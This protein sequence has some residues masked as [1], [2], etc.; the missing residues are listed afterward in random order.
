MRRYCSRCLQTLG[1][2][3]PDRCPG[4]AC[5]TPR[6]HRGWPSFLAEGTTIEERFIVHEI[7]GAGGAGITY[8]CED[9]TDPAQNSALKVLH[10]DRRHGV[11]ANRL[12]IEGELL[13]LLVHRHIV[14][15]HA[16]RLVGDGPVYLATRYMPGGSLEGTLRRQGPMRAPRVVTVGRQLALALDFIHSQGIVHRDL[17]PGNV[18]IETTDDDPVVRLADFG[19]ARVFRDQR[20]LAGPVGL[21]R[22]GVFIGTPEYAAPEQ[23][24]GEKDVGPA[25]DAFALGALL[26]YAACGGA[27]LKR[28]EIADWTA[29]RQRRPDPADRPRLADVVPDDVAAGYEDE[30]ADLDAIIDALMHPD[31]DARVS[32]CDVA[33]ALGAAPSDL[34]PRD[35][36]PLAPRTLISA[37]DDG[38]F[39]DDGVDALVPVDADVDDD[40]EGVAAVVAR[41][42]NLAELSSMGPSAAEAAIDRSLSGEPTVVVPRRRAVPPPSSGAV[43]P[44]GSAPPAVDPDPNSRPEW[45]DDEIDWPSPRSRRRNRV[46]AAFLG[47]AAML[48]GG[49]LAWPGGVPALIGEEPLQ[50]LSASIRGWIDALAVEEPEYFPQGP[51]DGKRVLTSAALGGPTVAPAP[52]VLATP[53]KQ[54]V[55][56]PVAPP[57]PAPAV[58]R[59]Q[60]EPVAVTTRPPEPEP[61]PD[62]VAS[63]SAD[64]SD[65]RT[66]PEVVKTEV[67]R[68]HAEWIEQLVDRYD[69]RAARYAA[70][71]HNDALR[72]AALLRAWDRQV[73]NARGFLR[74]P[75]PDGA[76]ADEH[77]HDADCH[78]TEEREVAAARH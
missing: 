1:S 62:P 65:V 46:H 78:S 43:P 14:P 18:L 15:F 72:Q 34:A 6:P 21:T 22:T 68:A 29:F 13:E 25:A 16:L 52:P 64:P 57:R 9:L 38:W 75:S 30:L 76:H 67:G 59:A 45:D 26:H 66:L 61:A 19:I 53:A 56:D 40:D 41:L 31:A 10:D 77:D 55:A 11:L 58:R 17:K 28:S 69:A 24:R 7:L 60:P 4:T 12:A 23:I 73:E 54:P 63:W 20:M 32:L 74:E 48:V 49:A 42:P 3:D 70:D 33:L 44:P 36:T 37:L 8:R 51:W 39:E 47:L 50:V 35:L 5:R 27:L 71:A 2:L